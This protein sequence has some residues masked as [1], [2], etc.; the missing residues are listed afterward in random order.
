M[1]QILPVEDEDDETEVRII[2]SSFADPYLLI[3][4]DDSSV[5]LFKAMDSG[6]VEEVEC[7]AF[8][9]AKWLS[10]SLFSPSFNSEVYAFL[11]TPDAGLQVSVHHGF[12][13][14]CGSNV[15]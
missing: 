5:K 10:A 8:S 13:A 12:E 6:E 14:S 1:D 4:C 3:L 9:S 11:L 7:S 15:V 2:S